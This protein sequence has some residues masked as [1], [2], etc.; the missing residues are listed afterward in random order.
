MTQ[1]YCLNSYSVLPDFFAKAR[2]AEII[3]LT[4]TLEE[5]RLGAILYPPKTLSQD[6]YY[7]DSP[8][9]LVEPKKSCEFR[10]KIECRG[11]RN[12]K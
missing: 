3:L 8:Q 11:C 7:T 4:R 1:D 6:I 12:L 10:R 9:N 5:R 2:I